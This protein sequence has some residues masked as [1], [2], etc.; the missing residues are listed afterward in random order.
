M[1]GQLGL[2]RNRT[3]KFLSYRNAA[4]RGASLSGERAAGARLIEAAIDSTDGRGVDGTSSVA[5]ALP[6][7]WVDTT[8]EVREIINV[9]RTKMNEL[10]VIYGKTL[11]TTFDDHHPDEVTIEVI[12]EDITQR[13]RRGQAK[14]KLLNQAPGSE[15]DAKVRT[16][17]QRS[18]AAELSQLSVEFRRQQKAYL[19]KVKQ[20]KEGISSG[21]D[22]F[23]QQ[24]SQWQWSDD[25]DRA[26]TTDQV[27]LVDNMESLV[28][29]RDME[30]KKILQSI[31]DLAQIMQDLSV[32]VIDQGTILDRI[33]YNMEQVSVK[34]Q[35]GVKQLERANKKQ[36]GGCRIMCIAMLAT[37]CILMLIILI[38]KSV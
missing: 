3:D 18:L 37:A 23:E 21:V 7:R 12:T 34:V 32:M 25:E 28:R 35:E 20:N 17:V 22:P 24:E 9:I 1:S 26:M 29:E 5:A 27:Q 33:D 8:S 15:D 19:G 36:K 38:I 14:L 13:F 30:I 2:T 16:N 6:P 11:L 10:K 31:N 4:R